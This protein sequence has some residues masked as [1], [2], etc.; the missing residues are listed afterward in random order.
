[1]LAVP[2][3]PAPGKHRASKPRVGRNGS[4]TRYTSQRSRC[5][6]SR[7]A[8][9]SSSPH[10][11]G[12]CNSLCPIRTEGCSSGEGVRNFV[13][14]VSV[15]GGITLRRYQERAISMFQTHQ[16]LVSCRNLLMI[17]LCRSPQFSAAH[18]LLQQT[19]TSSFLLLL[20]PPLLLSFRLHLFK[21]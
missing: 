21:K 20:L 11:S 17:Q 4:S 10:R 16:I 8:I 19:K 2:H 15:T 18:Q 13:K 7:P 14:Q 9:N 5:G 1:M 3:C 12:S 6:I